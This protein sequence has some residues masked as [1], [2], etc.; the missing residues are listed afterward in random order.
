MNN[1]QKFIICLEANDSFYERILRK[2]KEHEIRYGA[3]KLTELCEKKIIDNYHIIRSC[4]DAIK[5]ELKINV[6]DLLDLV[7]K[8]IMCSEELRYIITYNAS[9]N[10]SAYC[11][12]AL[13]L[14]PEV[15]QEL[16]QMFDDMVLSNK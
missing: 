10:C 7:N 11:L 12:R 1:L 6:F 16:N 9:S 14:L 8:M 13:D 2:Y 5:N 15:K 4:H 3:P